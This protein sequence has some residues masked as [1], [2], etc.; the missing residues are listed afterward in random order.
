MSNGIRGANCK[1][2]IQNTGQEC[3]AIRP[4]GSI[5]PV[6]PH[7]TVSGMLRGHGRHDDNRDETARQ[8]QEQSQIL[9]VRDD[10]VAKDDDGDAEP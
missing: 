7:E 3:H 8:D 4:P 6:G 10:T 9:Q 5:H 1:S 2:T